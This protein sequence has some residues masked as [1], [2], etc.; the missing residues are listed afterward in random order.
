LKVFDDFEKSLNK[1][2]NA[3]G[4]IFDWEQLISNIY[5]I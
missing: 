5:Y 1:Y 3:K 2:R 4:N